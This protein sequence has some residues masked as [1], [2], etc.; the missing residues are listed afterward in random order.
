VIKHAR[1]LTGH[2]RQF[3]ITQLQAGQLGDLGHYFSGNS[4]WA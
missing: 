2:Q 1:E 4:C 3:V